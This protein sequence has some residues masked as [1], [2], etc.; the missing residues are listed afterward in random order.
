MHTLNY[1]YKTDKITKY[2]FTKWYTLEI[3]DYC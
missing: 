2:N 1:E 3:T